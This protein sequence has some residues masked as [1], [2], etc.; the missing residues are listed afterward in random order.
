MSHETQNSKEALLLRW[1]LYVLIIGTASAAATYRLFHV[2]IMDEQTRLERDQ[3]GSPMLCAND[4]SRWCTIRALGDQGKYEIDDIIDD[5]KTHR[6]SFAEGKYDR[7][8]ITIDLVK[9]RDAEG[10]M[11]YYSSKPTLFPTM[12]AYLYKAV[13]VVTGKDIA[14]DTF[15]VVHIMLIIVNIVPMAIFLLL[16]AATLEV[17]T[18]DLFTKIM[19]VSAASFGTFLTPFAIT[20]NNH[21]PAAFSA[22]ITLFA[23]VHILNR[24]TFP[25]HYFLAGLFSAFTAANELPALSFFCFVAFILL[26]RS[27]LK[28]MLLFAP[29]AAIVV[30][31]FFMT[32]YQAHNDWV[33]A[34][35]HRSDGKVI[36][37]VDEYI[38]RNVENLIVSKEL[39]A[40]L[41]QYPDKLGF[42][43]SAETARL[44]EGQM[45]VPKEVEKRFVLTQSD[46]SQRVAIVKLK[47][48]VVEIRQWNNWYE[49]PESPW[50]LPN[51][52]GV[53][54]GEPDAGVYAFHCLV[55]HHGIFSLTPLW[56]LSL[57]GMPMLFRG[58]Y[59]K[60][61]W[62]GLMTMI[63]SLVVVAF[64]LSRPLEDRNYGGGTS[65]LRWLLWLTPLWIYSAVPFVELISKSIWGKIIVV[66]LVAASIAS[67][68]YSAMNPW[69]HP[70]LYDV[71][72]RMEWIEAFDAR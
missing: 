70:W 39:V 67:C 8:W 25:G 41:N 18:D 54:Q 23:L 27:P 15:E 40:K 17:L 38:F 55:G 9:H 21:L 43:V 34:Y 14:N 11:H 59:R 31:G 71:L 26:I 66:L 69:V 4:R 37:E 28:T 72:V 30:A 42:R 44:A 3:A 48:G 5:P 33:P 47:S 64:Y 22:G 49:Y 35:A 57:C 13:N 16:M 6:F 68:H 19:L 46:D 52:S 20:L 60:F 65:A 63:V 58:N 62:V 61:S 53:D 56:I 24:S 12:L 7:N 51:K 10:T 32:N 1:F 2:N 50:L 29:G 45:P 36:T